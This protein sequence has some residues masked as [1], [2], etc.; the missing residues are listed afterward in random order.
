MS[1][2]LSSRS[3]TTGLG[4]KTLPLPLMSLVIDCRRQHRTG[5]RV[6][7][8]LGRAGRAVADDPVD[9]ARGRTGQDRQAG[10]RRGRGL[11]LRRS[12]GRSCRRRWPRSGQPWPWPVRSCWRRRRSRRHPRRRP[13]GRRRPGPRRSVRVDGVVAAQH[14]QATRNLLVP[15]VGPEQRVL[16]CHEPQVRGDGDLRRRSARRTRRERHQG[17]RAHRKGGGDQ[18]GNSSTMHGFTPL[19][20]NRPRARS[21]PT[22]WVGFPTPKPR[23]NTATPGPCW[24]RGCWTFTNCCWLSPGGCGASCGRPAEVGQL[25]VSFSRRAANASSE[26]SVPSASSAASAGAVVAEE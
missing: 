25:P 8:R 17:G 22:G 13:A 9:Q 4:S 6:D 23:N 10:R 19:C 2:R 7:Q 14:D 1:L 21:K 26:A 11:G 16:R 15:L 24:A 12:P 18:A 3:E 5:R 20:S